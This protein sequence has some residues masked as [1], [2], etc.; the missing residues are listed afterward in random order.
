MIYALILKDQPEHYR[1]VGATINPIRDR[2]IGHLNGLRKN[3]P[4]SF[5]QWKRQNRDCIDIVE[6]ES[7]ADEDLSYKE[8]AWM[9]YLFDLQHDLYNVSTAPY[10]EKYVEE[11]RAVLSDSISRGRTGIQFTREHRNNIAEAQRKNAGT[12]APRSE[13]S[14]RAI[15]E[16][17]KISEKAAT[18]RKALHEFNTGRALP[19]KHKE[20]VRLA[21]LQYDL[22]HPEESKI[23][24]R[25]GTMTA[26][27]NRWHIGRGL[28][29]ED[30]EHCADMTDIE[31]E[32]FLERAHDGD[33]QPKAISEAKHLKYHVNRGIVDP[34]CVRCTRHLS[35]AEIK[36]LHRVAN[37]D[38]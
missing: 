32:K 7:C 10:G 13:E 24:T 26:L 33:T 30:C 37:D 28:I 2:L 19:D 4:N 22:A 35:N 16:I 34:N 23:N 5:K 29:A 17:L 11:N 27:H 25:K 9:E 3:D 18:Q 14:R 1:Y 31:I 12:Y 20:N 6:L 15:S 21:K 38:S 36:E 8:L